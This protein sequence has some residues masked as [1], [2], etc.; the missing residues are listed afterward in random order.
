[1]TPL[2]HSLIS[3]LTPLPLPIMTTLIAS[4]FA[5]IGFSFTAGTLRERLSETFVEVK[6]QVLDDVADA[7]AFV[8]DLCKAIGNVFV[9]GAKYVARGVGLAG[10]LAVASPWL[11]GALLAPVWVVVKTAAE[12]VRDGLVDTSEYIEEKVV[13][14][15]FRLTAFVKLG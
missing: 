12:L 15:L 6:A 13:T 10:I 4:L 3:F 7:H 5:A 11:V 9:K 2:T 8:V 14:G 1:M